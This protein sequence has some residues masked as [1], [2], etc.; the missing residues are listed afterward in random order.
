MTANAMKAD[1]D[2]CLAAGMNDHV[3]KP[4]DRKAL[5]QTLRRWLPARRRRRRT[6]RG[7]SGPA[8]ALTARRLQRIA[9]GSPRLEGIDVAGSLD[10]LG[11]EFETLPADARPVR[12][13]P[14]SD[15]RRAA[16]RRGRPATPPRPPDMPTP[17]P[18][19]R[20][21]SAPT[22]CVPPPRRSSAPAAQ[23]TTGSR[24]SARRSGSPGR[25]GLP[26][27]RHAAR[28]PSRRLAAEPGH[29]VRSR[30]EAR[31]G[32]GA[33]A[34]GA[35]RLR[36]VGGEQRARRSRSRRD[37]GQPPA[38]WLGLR[39]HVDGYEYEEAR[40]LVDPAARTDRSRGAVTESKPQLVAPLTAAALIAQQV[41][42]NAIRDG[43]FL[44]LFPV[45]SLPYFM[46][47]RGRARDR[48]RR[49][50]RDGC[51]PGSGPAR[52]RSRRS[53]ASNAALFLVE[54]VLLG[55]QPRAAAVLLYLHSSVLGAIAISAFW[56]LLNER[57]DPHSAKPLMARVA[58]AATFGGFVGGVSAERVA[59]LLPQGALLLLLASRRRGLR[60]RR[61][62]RGKRSAR[63]PTPA[64]GRAGPRWGVGADSAPAPAAGPGARHRA[65]GDARGARGLSS[66]GRGGRAIS[67]RASSWCASSACSTPG[68]AWRRC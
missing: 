22:A 59:A 20:A 37:A 3:T 46:A 32:P 30:G 49:S 38:I 52:R 24:P 45:Q 62:G 66:Q 19:R 9:D 12:G 17:S 42:A 53:F 48:S 16:R 21:I 47:G 58:A 15:A 31:G 33:P 64:R 39:N 5:L 61:R 43:L 54:W 14:G 8:A 65:R 11:L 13:Q 35:R 67:E 7:V 56:S 57:F 6:G 41:G 18:G 60:R 10:R 28:S 34:G 68:P 51:W 40:V 2:A 1:L 55:W 27:H 44:S 23:A 25:R 36:P 63:Q 29:A 4:I 26:L 50:S